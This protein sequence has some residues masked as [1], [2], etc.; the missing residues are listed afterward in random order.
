MVKWNYALSKLDISQSSITMHF[1]GVNS[2]H[3]DLLIG[4]DGVNSAV[5]KNVLMERDK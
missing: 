4:C 3:T 5:R 1:P 2:I